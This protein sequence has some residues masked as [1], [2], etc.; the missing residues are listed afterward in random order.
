MLFLVLFST[1]VEAGGER[2]ADVGSTADH[3]RKFVLQV[4]PI[5]LLLRIN[6]IKN[7]RVTRWQRSRNAWL[8]Q[9]FQTVKLGSKH[10]LCFIS[11]VWDALSLG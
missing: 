11:F 4:F 3:E 6:C 1:L 10:L 7:E 8:N 2:M 9:Q 5:E